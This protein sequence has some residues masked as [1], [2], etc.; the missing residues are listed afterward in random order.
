MTIKLYINVFSTIITTIGTVI[1]VWQAIKI[2]RYKNEVRVDRLKVFLLDSI[3][4]SAFIKKESSKLRT[5][6]NKDFTRGFD[7]QSI[8]TVIENYLYDVKEL[9]VRFELNEIL[10]MYKEVE[11][12]VG[13]YKKTKPELRFSIGDEIDRKVNDLIIAMKRLALD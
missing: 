7:I 9:A 6:V 5:P 2:Y 8:L 3:T 12:L 1:T 10:S 13:D 4:A 11:I